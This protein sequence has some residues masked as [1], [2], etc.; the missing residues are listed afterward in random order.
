MYKMNLNKF[1]SVVLQV[2]ICMVILVF[3]LIPYFIISFYFVLSLSQCE[4]LI[5]L[6]LYTDIDMC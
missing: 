6:A 5:V 1:A 4:E 2:F 3:H